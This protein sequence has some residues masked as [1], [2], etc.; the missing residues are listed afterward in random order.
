[1]IKFTFSKPILDDAGHAHIFFGVA[2]FYREAVFRSQG[3]NWQPAQAWDDILFVHSD[4]NDMDDK[5]LKQALKD[6]LRDVRA[7]APE[8]LE[9]TREI[10]GNTEAPFYQH[11][12]RYRFQ[13]IISHRQIEDGL[14]FGYRF[15]EGVAVVSEYRREAGDLAGARAYYVQKGRREHINAL[16][17]AL[18]LRG[19]TRLP[20]GEKKLLWSRSQHWNL[21]EIGGCYYVDSYT[22][23]D[24]TEYFYEVAGMSDIAIGP[25]WHAKQYDAEAAVGML[26]AAI[27]STETV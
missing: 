2:G 3:K 5:R 7:D 9:I 18:D 1:M 20:D 16:C 22:A 14:S 8:I 11:G 23:S 4:Q 15:D 6:A 10:D 26:L 19:I 24:S 27:T 17:R 25:C 12:Y 21:I 13:R